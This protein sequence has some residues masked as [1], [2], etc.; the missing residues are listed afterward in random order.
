MQNQARPEEFARLIQ[1]NQGIL[2]R[3]CR[4]YCRQREDRED[5]FQE[6]I[7]QAWK[8][9][10]GFRAE[11]K[12]TTWLY[13]IALNTAISGWRRKKR[14]IAIV[15][16]PILTEIPAIAYADEKDEQMKLLFQAIDQLTDLEKA[17]ITLYLEDR[18]YEEMEDVFGITQNNLRVKMNRIK[19]KLRKI[20]G[21][22]DG[23][24]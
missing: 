5:L 8:S 22:N 17:I 3:I 24:R 20:T 15:D 21:N 14:T 19:D 11:S 23:N 2:Y 16:Q 7:I 12:F 4:I 13:R 10:K 18:S 1:E 9:Y 6:M